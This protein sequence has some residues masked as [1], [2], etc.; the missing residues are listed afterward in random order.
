MVRTL[1]DFL[2]LAILRRIVTSGSLSLT[3]P[4]GSTH[5]LDSGMPGPDAAIIL[6]DR[7][8][9]WRLITQPDLGFGEGYMDGRI[10]VGD[11]GIE[12]L[13]ELLMC[14]AA[15]WRS[16]WTGRLT[17][18][19]GNSLAWL[20]HLNPPERSKRNVAHHYDLTDALFETFLDPWRQYSCAYFHSDEDGL[21]AAQVT[22]LA[23][24]AAKLNL[25]AGDRVLDIGCGWGGLARALTRCREGIS[26]TGITL[27]EQ[28]LDHAKR[29]AGDP[30][31]GSRLEF[32]LRDYRRQTGQLDRIVSVGMLEHVGPASIPTYFS[33]VRRLLAPGGVAV[34]HSI[35]VHNKSGPV[36]R[37]LSRYI[38]PG[39]YLPS[40]QQLVGTAEAHGLK[41]LDVEIMRGHYAETLRH[42]RV[43]FLAQRD[44][45]AALYD[46][47]F[48]RMWEFY[49]VGCEYFF[50]CQHGMVVQLQLSDD[51]QAVPKS[52]QYITLLEQIFRDRLCQNAPSGKTNTSAT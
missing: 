42:W 44:Q 22:K 21:E 8:T 37:W 29:V 13:V 18:C 39:G 15:H 43:R 51:H 31:T 48:I 24:L 26:V 46:E 7:A 25:Q 35:A 32:A 19:L 45:V 33:M 36:N 49:L 11:G 16:H 52:R 23:R 28:Q 27:S 10:T 3:L 40:T 2:A 34:I 4:D 30:D 5:R 1:F 6:H 50:R 41:I 20:R 12:A 14:N 47:R 38:F 17:L 9:L